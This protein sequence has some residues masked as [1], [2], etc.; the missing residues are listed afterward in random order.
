M[1]FGKSYMETLASPSFPQEW[2][3][4]AIEY[5]H[6]KKLINGVVAELESLGL[7]ADVLREL[8][9]PGAQSGDAHEEEDEDIRMSQ[10]AAAA[11]AKSSLH[12]SDHSV[13]ARRSSQSSES[14]ARSRS[15]T[16]SGTEDSSADEAATTGPG[17]YGRLLVDSRAARLAGSESG[18]PLSPLIEETG[19]SSSRTSPRTIGRPSAEE[20]APAISLGVAA[21]SPS[22]TLEAQKAQRA[23]HGSP[24]EVPSEDC[25]ECVADANAKEAARKSLGEGSQS[26]GI[27]ASVSP[28]KAS[29]HESPAAEWLEK[30][31]HSQ[32]HQRRRSA[33]KSSGGSQ[34]A[35]GWASS[36]GSP[37]SSRQHSVDVSDTDGA[38]RRRQHHHQ[39]HHEQ[40]QHQNHEEGPEA[41]R[42][43]PRLLLKPHERPSAFRKRSSADGSSGVGSPDAVTDDETNQWYGMGKKELEEFRRRKS[44]V[45]G[46]GPQKE[47]DVRRASMPAHDLEAGKRAQGASAANNHGRHD[48]GGHAWRERPGDAWK[49][50]NDTA[51]PS[52]SLRDR[53]NLAA[54]R[55]SSGGAA[56]KQPEDGHARKSRWVK[57]KDGRRARAEYELGGTKEH[58]VPRIRLFVESPVN[59]GDEGSAEESASEDDSTS[60]AGA[61]DAGPRI[62]E[63]PP[64]PKT[65]KGSPGRE[66]AV[67]AL[68][69]ASLPDSTSTQRADADAGLAPALS[70]EQFGTSAA[71]SH[72]GRRMRHREIVIP[73]TADTEFLDTLTGALQNLSNLQSAQRDAF[74]QQT[75]SLCSAVARV[76]SPY[77]TKSDLYVWREIFALYVEMQIF[78]SE[79]EKD[80]GE[81]SVDES[82]ARLK[83]FA[84]EL[85]KRGWTTSNESGEDAQGG[86]SGHKHRG[87]LAARLSRRKS[88]AA[89]ASAGGSLQ[90]MKDQRS[91]NAL[92]DF[93]RLN[94]ALLDVK[95]FQRVNIEAARKILKKHDKR[96]ALTASDD[97]RAFIAQQDA[98]RLGAATVAGMGLSGLVQIPPEAFGVGSD[99]ASHRSG[100]L[101]P[102]GGGTHPSLAA[103]LPSSTTGILAESLP[104][105]LL[106][107]LTTTL[108]PILPSIDDYACAI[109]TELKVSWVTLMGEIWTKRLQS[110]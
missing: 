84:E 107:L 85:A 89:G 34:T 7:G 45:F 78:E 56:G 33:R 50:E 86:M 65:L 22:A 5:K 88:S 52:G 19:L 12:P 46:D 108:L 64:T 109:C 35:G 4:G 29:S 30:I 102:T 8:I 48:W 94:L 53:P 67:L 58:P 97:L 66:P 15:L 80:R 72:E 43:D 70:P 82:E 49:M 92:Q 99:G 106:S 36:D 60:D 21:L 18:N 71:R 2:R 3:E 38:A 20:Q 17:K 24:L 55:S 110:L 51:K 32:P 95:K 28:S 76:A 100:A 11:A 61:E 42:P 9:A 90:P 10:L 41:L 63:L 74:Q 59:S 83:R 93:L 26:N 39:H 54:R 1:K 69:N 81:V 40:H 62:T 91:V 13:P 98:T 79:R 87:G 68:P 37:S 44:E 101:V 75:E 57:G 6:L 104:H 105:I 96:T 14:R 73:L 103:L 25:E 77:A 23:A 16:S 31:A 27:S 47:D